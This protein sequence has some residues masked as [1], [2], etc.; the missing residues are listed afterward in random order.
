[1]TPGTS[2]RVVHADPDP[3]VRRVLRDELG[4][5][6]IHVVA[7]T[8]DGRE[9]LDLAA[10]HRPDLLLT[11]LDL[12]GFEDV[13]ALA[14]RIAERVPGVA[15]IV[16]TA[17]P[18]DPRVLEALRAGANGVI[19]KGTATGTLARA[20]RRA[21]QGEALIPRVLG[22]AVLGGLRAVPSQG[23]R[24]LHSH[25]TT[26]EWEI[27]EL[28]DAGATTHD[29]AEQLYLSPATVYSH[30]KNILRKLEVRSR[31]EAVE[32]ARRLRPAEVGLAGARC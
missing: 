11:A 5:H 30:V 26:R 18:G 32:A 24:P 22:S 19:D 10:Y 16:L 31:K 27:V 17:D 15:T 29:I 14:A 13:V 2:I 12:A 8:A 9:A 23:W 28:L 4:T 3:L 6:G 21:A 1:M 25:L 20:L 7:G